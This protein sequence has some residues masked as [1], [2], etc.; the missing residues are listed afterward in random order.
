MVGSALEG[1]FVQ[2]LVGAVGVGGVGLS[3]CL[4]GGVGRREVKLCVDSY[5]LETYK[6]NHSILT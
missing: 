4:V 2:G 6:V 3:A 5:V 1:A